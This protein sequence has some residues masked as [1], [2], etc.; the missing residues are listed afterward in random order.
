MNNIV[1]AGRVIQAKCNWRHD[2]KSCGSVKC[3]Q[4]C[5]NAW[6]RKYAAILLESAKTKP[7]KQHV[8][9][10][11]D[12]R[13][14]P[15]EHGFQND[16]IARF[17]K[18]LRDFGVEYCC[19]NE[20]SPKGK[21]HQHLLIRSQA[22]WTAKQI[23]ELAEKAITA[24]QKRWWSDGEPCPIRGANV[25]V[26]D[27]ASAEVVPTCKYVV[28]DVLDK[29]KHSYPPLSFSGRV[30]TPTKGYLSDSSSNLWRAVRRDWFGE[31]YREGY[32]P[33]MF[34]TITA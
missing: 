27:L 19:V 33:E 7:P 10:T 26:H 30:L 23:R 18:K 13:S 8:R 4:Q 15:D 34:Q 21:R 32:T 5:R 9:L 14:D 29:S 1:F 2:G 25:A 28:K 31:S 17:L 16:V 11:L 3:S 22:T 24:H 20:W 6:S 12:D